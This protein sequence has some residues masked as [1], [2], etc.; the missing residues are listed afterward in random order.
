MTVTLSLWS[1][2]PFVFINGELPDRVRKAVDDELSYEVQGHEHTDAWQSGEWDGKH[3]LLRQS[4]NG[5]WYFPV[6]VLEKVQQ[7]LDAY[8][9]SHETEGLTRPGRGDL[10]IEWHSDME[11][12]DYQREAVDRCLGQGS[13]LVV[14]PTGAGKTIVGLYLLSV[15]CRPAVVLVHRKEIAS[16]WVERIQDILGVEPALCYGGVREAGDVQVALY[17]SVIEDGDV[18]DDVRLDHDVVLF[19]EADVV[20]ADT[21]SRVA[22]AITA[23]YR[24]GFTATEEREDGATLRV[25]GGAGPIIADLSPEALIDRGWLAEPEWIIKEAPSSGSRYRD[26]QAEYKAEIVNNNRRNQLISQAVEDADKPCMVTVER[27]A[28]GNRLEALTDGAAFVHGDSTDREE[29]IHM[30]REGDLDVLVAT[31]GIVG[32]GFDVPE[33]ESFCVAGGLKSETSTIQQV[34]RA[35]RPGETGTAQIIDFIDS[36]QWI[37]KHSEERLRVY[38]EYYGKYSP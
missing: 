38:Q 24:F 9:V 37:G 11:L 36:G 14:M 18:R 20:G 10:D 32:R 26:W 35:L 27:I 4:K 22:M 15:L 19:D 16:Q 3:H 12:R 33:I 7:A 17:Q 8:G 25:I 29:T 30:F 2:A 28:H 6:G 31:R 13:G 34:G 21:F 23:P 5:N 1:E